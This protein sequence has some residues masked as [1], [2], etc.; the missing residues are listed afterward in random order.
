MNPVIN[1]VVATD[2]MGGIGCSKTNSIPWR[3]P[4]DAR[5]FKLITTY[6]PPQPED[7]K[8]NVVIMGKNT[9]ASLPRTMKPLPGRL[10]IVISRTLCQE[11]EEEE[12]KE[13]EEVLFFPSLSEVL[14]WISYTAYNLGFIF[15]IGGSFL[16]REA[17]ETIPLS[18][19]NVIWTRVA[20]Q[21][22]DDC[23]IRVPIEWLST[24]CNVPIR[25]WIDFKSHIIC[26]L[27]TSNSNEHDDT[28]RLGTATLIALSKTPC[29]LP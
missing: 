21:V 22:Q 5:L 25:T 24:H 3:I 9:W 28:G 29:L 20:A 4:S 12:K 27:L 7:Q 13:T 2:V 15:L 18:Q 10:N 8:Q 14:S 26:D 17:M 16:Y 6:R 1:M 11:E 19:L 23:D